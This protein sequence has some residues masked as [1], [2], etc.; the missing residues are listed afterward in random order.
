[1]NSGEIF[2]IKFLRRNRPKLKAGN[3]KEF[4][5]CPGAN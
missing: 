5:H 2:K 1:M 4:Q 3:L